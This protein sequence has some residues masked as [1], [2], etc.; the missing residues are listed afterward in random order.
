M[1]LFTVA[2]Y[3]TMPLALSI[4]TAFL[5]IDMPLVLLMGI[6]VEWGGMLI[7]ILSSVLVFMSETLAWNSRWPVSTL[8]R[9]VFT[10]VSL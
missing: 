6:S 10:Y 5:S 7:W 9:F 4:S 8:F 2:V 1:S 3:F